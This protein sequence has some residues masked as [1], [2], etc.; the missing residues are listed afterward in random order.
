MEGLSGLLDA[1]AFGFVLVLCRVG[2]VAMLLPGIGEAELPMTVRTAIAMALTVLLL[3]AV[4]PRLVPPPG[5]TLPLAALLFGEMAVGLW[6]GWMARVAVQMLPIVGQVLAATA[7][8]TNIIQPDA[9]I[10]GQSSAI[11]HAFTLA[12]PLLILAGNLHELPLR[13]LAHSY[14]WLPPGA[15]L[16]S[17]D[18]ASVALG[19][20]GAGFDTV[21]R[22]A[23]PVVLAGVLWQVCLSLLSRLVPQL[24]IYFAAMPGQLAGGLLLLATLGGGIVNGWLEHVRAAFLQAA[25]L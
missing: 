11:S 6:L 17:G 2:C 24:Q 14:D 16:L 21:L 18:A 10:G 3:P 13:A 4:Q 8:M 20:L 9:E 22:L 25:A 12:A 23:G 19:A 7:G 15:P 5:A 1:Y